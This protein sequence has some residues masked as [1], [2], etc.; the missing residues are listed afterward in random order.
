MAAALFRTSGCPAVGGISNPERTVLP[1]EGD[2]VRFLG[3]SFH[4]WSSTLGLVA[5]FGLQR[6]LVA[7]V[8]RAAAKKGGAALVRAVRKRIYSLSFCACVLIIGAAVIVGGPPVRLS[9]IV[10]IGI[11][12]V[13]AVGAFLRWRNVELTGKD[14]DIMDE[15]R[16]DAKCGSESGA[17]PDLGNA[18]PGRALRL[19]RWIGGHLGNNS[20]RPRG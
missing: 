3:S 12:I 16:E 4:E 1:D 13:F 10:F 2:A 15:P 11:M 17:E 6:L 14:T 5:L 8:V 18:P 20:R 19:G 7:R 9:N